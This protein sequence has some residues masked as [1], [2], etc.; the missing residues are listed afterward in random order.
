MCADTLFLWYFRVTYYWELRIA[1]IVVPIVNSSF[2]LTK[3][4]KVKITL[5]MIFSVAYYL[6]LHN[7][8]IGYCTSHFLLPK[9]RIDG[10]DIIE[11]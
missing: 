7:V 2:Y 3:K 10:L 9:G 5:N 6:E 1:I 11:H 4:K 8:V